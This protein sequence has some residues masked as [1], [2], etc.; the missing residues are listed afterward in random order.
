METGRREIMKEKIV[1]IADIKSRNTGGRLIGH[2]VPVA[3]N[4]QEIFADRCKVKVCGGPVY[5]KYF[6]GD[7]F[8]QLPYDN[9]CDSLMEKLRTFINAICLFYKARHQVIVLQQ[10]TPITAFL[11]IICFYWFTGKL[12]LIQYNTE[13]VNSLLKRLVYWCAKW[14]IDGFIVPNERVGKAF[15]RNYCIA[16]DYIYCGREVEMLPFAKRKWDFSIVGSIFKDKGSVPALEFLASKGYN[17][18]IAGGVGE[19]ELLKPLHEIIDKYPNIEHH[20][21]F[22]SNDDFRFYIRNSRYCVLNYRGTY[23]DRSSGVVLDVLFNGTPV[24]GTRCSALQ[25]V[26]DGN[27][28]F[29]Y[30]DISEMDNANLFDETTY[31]HCLSNISGYLRTQCYVRDN[32]CRF[33]L[34]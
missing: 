25:M 6:G 26:E 13:S 3:K 28:G 10:S 21:G 12:Y 19:Q 29:L 31:N 9:Y 14:K 24:V 27:L 17:V 4:Y 8:M 2:F 11:A 34:K 30:E 32:L 20:I 23:F 15:S 16:T 22:I 5:G 7:E 1:Y 33:V 18:L